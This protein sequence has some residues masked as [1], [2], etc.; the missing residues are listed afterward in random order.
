MYP[1]RSAASPTLAGSALYAAVWRWH[2]YAA[3]FVVPF[4]VLL[5]ITGGIYLFKPQIESCL[6]AG[7]Y[8]VAPATQSIGADDQVQLALSQFAG[9]RAE[10]Y[11]PPAAP[12]KSALVRAVTRDHREI[13]VAVDPH[14]GTILG[15]IDEQWCPMQVVRDLHGTL[16]AG[17][18]G[19]VLQE[20]AASWAMVLLVTG[21]FLWW[22]RQAR[23]I[24]GTILPRL[25]LRGRPL[26]RDLHAVTGFWVSGLLVFLVATG[27]PWTLVSGKIFS[28]VAGVVGAGNPATG[29]GWD[30]GGSTT[31]K[32]DQPDQGWATSHAEHLA[33]V[34]HSVPSHGAVRLPLAK[35]VEM[36]SAMPGIAP[37]FEI[38]FPVDDRGVFSIVT[39][40][41][42]DPEGTAYVHLD[43]YTGQVIADVRWKDFGPVARGI[44]LGVSL[45]E[46]L[47][48]GLVNQLIGL[49]ACLGL[50]GMAT[51]GTVMWWRRRP[52]GQLGAP[53]APIG[54]RAGPAIIGMTIVLGILMPLMAASLVLVLI[55]DWV[56]RHRTPPRFAAMSLVIV[57][58]TG[59]RSRKTLPARKL[60]RRQTC[61]WVRSW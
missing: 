2:F 4:A 19:Q 46:G 42:R 13:T 61:R 23:A 10:A 60:A 32:S 16:L 48:F 31:L 30:K 41:E 8:N 36:A 20:L 28:E 33:G 57:F 17:T 27:L 25:S 44:A 53:S 37:P 35:V 21:L 38:R 26:W 47:Y 34:A 56:V 1:A 7:L 45:H 3:L 15:T 59:M 51:A 55:L 18:A 40:S 29:L 24:W 5:A 22:P 50:V 49:V 12:T 43:Q 6:Y 39:D 58:F 52:A 11:T 9:S 14:R 54:Y